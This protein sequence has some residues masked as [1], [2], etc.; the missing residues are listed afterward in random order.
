MKHVRIDLVVIS[1]R[2]RRTEGLLVRLPGSV[3]VLPG[4]AV[5]PGL[6]L[7]QAAR[8]ALAEQ[9]ADADLAARFAPLAKALA[10]H[11]QTIVDELN[12]VQ[13]QPVDIGGYYS[14]DPELAAAAMRPRRSS[15]RS[16]RCLRTTARPSTLPQ[17]RWAP[18][19]TRCR[20]RWA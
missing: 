6:T 4:A 8:E 9:T 10:E 18:R 12:A 13:G 14:P 3:W 5:P 2:E 16:L 19:S 17:P 1:V 7:E 11:E 20:R 15:T